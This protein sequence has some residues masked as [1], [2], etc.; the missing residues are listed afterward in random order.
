MPLAQQQ[1]TEG[2][3]HNFPVS[4]HSN[5]SETQAKIRLLDTNE[6]SPGSTAW[7]QIT[8]NEKLHLLE[9]DRFIIRSA[10]T[11]IGGGTVIKI[12]AKRHRRNSPAVITALKNIES[13]QPISKGRMVLLTIC[14]IVLP[15]QI[16]RLDMSTIYS[17]VKNYWPTG[18]GLFTI[19]DLFL[20]L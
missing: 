15:V 1:T 11:T 10:D 20:D 2:I 3:R 5:T 6:I 12:D 16:S 18:W 19:S 4:F 7:A 8:L 14:A 9:G 17:D 13:D